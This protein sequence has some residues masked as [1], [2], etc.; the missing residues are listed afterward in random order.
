MLGTGDLLITIII[1]LIY[2]VFPQLS[3][4]LGLFGVTLL[5]PDAIFTSRSSSSSSFLVWSRRFL[6]LASLIVSL[7][8][9]SSII[10]TPSWSNS[11][12]ERTL[13]ERYSLYYGKISIQDAI[14]ASENISKNQNAVI[15]PLKTDKEWF[16][17]RTSLSSRVVM[18]R[19]I[20]LSGETK[21]PVGCQTHVDCLKMDPQNVSFVGRPFPI[22]SPVELQAAKVHLARIRSWGF[23]AIRLL[24][25]WEAVEHE[26][27][28]TYDHHYLE[29]VRSVVQLCATFGLG[30]II[31]FHQD[32][33]SR[34]SGGDGVR[35]A[36]SF[37]LPRV[38][39]S[40][41]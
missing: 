34:F 35:F 12:K 20:N 2:E 37:R 18:I 33:W 10:H 25:S 11:I 26:G 41:N 4:I 16:R 23:N 40:L 1:T 32:L 5:L 22:S 7:L 31:D 3:S 27:P 15:Y 39:F 9:N 29:Y 24:V 30:V 19:A 14:E 6:A 13:S 28:G 17:E 8:C 36:Y 21:F 38:Y